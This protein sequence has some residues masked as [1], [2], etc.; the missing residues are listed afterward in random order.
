MYFWDSSRRTL[1]TTERLDDPV[2]YDVYWNLKLRFQGA[3]GVLYPCGLEMIS[4]LIPDDDEQVGR[5]IGPIPLTKKLLRQVPPADMQIRA[6][7]IFDE[8]T[9]TESGSPTAYDVTRPVRKSDE[10]YLDL[11]MPDTTD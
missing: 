9:K 2:D 5:P 11:D 3:R 8:I 4:V 10:E 6:K 1:T 7:T